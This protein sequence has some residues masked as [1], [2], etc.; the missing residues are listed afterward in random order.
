MD[1]GMARSIGAIAMTIIDFLKQKMDMGELKLDYYNP[2]VLLSRVF[3]LSKTDVGRLIKQGAVRLHRN[4]SMY[5]LV[6]E[7]AKLGM[8][9]FDRD[10]FSKGRFYVK[11]K[12]FNHTKEFHV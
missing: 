9:L 3:K 12:G 4:E 1:I 8:A 6:P 5:K 11:L 7:D 10:I 2:T